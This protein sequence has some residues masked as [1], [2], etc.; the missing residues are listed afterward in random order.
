[1]LETHHRRT[2]E[3]TR[4]SGGEVVK[5]PRDGYL[6]AFRDAHSALGRSICLQGQYRK[7]AELWRTAED[8]PFEVCVSSYGSCAFQLSQEGD[9]FGAPLNRSARLP[10]VCSGGQI[11]LR[12]A[13]NKP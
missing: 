4:K 9:D 11:L 2:E 3:T 8:N 5:N 13:H 10:E 7:L 12:R 6:H 1:M